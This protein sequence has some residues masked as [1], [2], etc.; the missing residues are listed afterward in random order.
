MP[1]ARETR[2]Y[3]KVFVA[4]MSWRDDK[5]YPEEFVWTDEQKDSVR[6]H[7]VTSY[8][9]LRAYG[10]DEIDEDDRPTMIRANTLKT[11]KRS[12]SYFMRRRSE[13]DPIDERGNP[14]RSPEVQDFIK[15]VELFQCRGEGAP[16]QA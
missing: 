1:N 3:T 2:R 14:T 6:P 4:F 11:I 12:I 13:W 9:A 15:Q 16:S 10:K 7:H 8:M 5:H